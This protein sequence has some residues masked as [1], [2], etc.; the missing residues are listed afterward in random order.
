MLRND[1]S[2]YAEF[3]KGSPTAEKSSSN[4][5]VSGYVGS[6]EEGVRFR[7]AYGLSDVSGNFKLPVYK[8]KKCSF[9]VSFLAQ[10][11]A[12]ESEMDC[13]TDNYG[14]F[15][16]ITLK[17][18]F[19]K[20]FWTMIGLNK[21]PC[22]DIRRQHEG[23]EIHDYNLKELAMLNEPRPVN[24]VYV[25]EDADGGTVSNV[26]FN[27]CLNG[28]SDSVYRYV[29]ATKFS[30]RAEFTFDSAPIIVIA[31]LV[32]NLVGYKNKHWYLTYV[33]GGYITIMSAEE[34]R[35]DANHYFI[36]NGSLLRDAN[37]T[38][39]VVSSGTPLPIIEVDVEENLFKRVEYRIAL[40]DLWK[41]NYEDSEV[42]VGE[43]NTEWLEE[44][45]EK[46]KVDD[47]TFDV[48]DFDNAGFED[49]EF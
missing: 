17:E 23:L 16:V 30:S 34:I 1:E 22:I 38:T 10:Y 31:E 33:L 27:P 19:F 11:T 46:C 42:P 37:H 24:V 36:T 21:I 48:P 12:D 32:D 4:V 6:L 26:G 7:V 44:L 13:D 43:G 29:R 47:L 9:E 2:T 3:A 20:Y 5:S 45:L 49:G 35:D 41:K 18:D 8:A 14:S 25:N 39:V 15:K 40:A 28:N